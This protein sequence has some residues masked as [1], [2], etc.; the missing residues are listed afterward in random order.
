MSDSNEMPHETNDGQNKKNILIN[1]PE[2]LRSKILKNVE[3]HKL[4]KVLFASTEFYKIISS[5]YSL[6]N[7]LH[8]MIVNE[9]FIYFR[10][11]SSFIDRIKQ[12]C[13]DQKYIRKGIKESKMELETHQVDITKMLFDFDNNRIFSSSDDQTVVLIENNQVKG[14]FVGHQ[15]GIWTFGF[16]NNKLVTG[17]TDK[18]IRVW[19]IDTF[20]CQLV[21]KGHKNTIRCIKVDHEHI[22]SGGR[23][24]EIRIWNY[25]GECLHILRGH[26]QSVRCMDI[27]E[28]LLV[29]GSYDGSVVL[30]D[31]KSGQKVKQ[32][33]SHSS[34][35]YCVK[36][37]SKYVASAGID[38]VIHVSNTQ[39]IFVTVLIGHR[40]IIAWLNIIDD[41]LISAGADGKCIKYNI[42]TGDLCYRIR[43]FGHIVLMNYC[44]G[45][46]VLGTNLAVNLYCFRTGKFVRKI[47]DNQIIVYDGIFCKNQIIIGRKHDNKTVITKYTY[48]V[49]K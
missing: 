41:E 1:L 25:Q 11:P 14:T 23:D 6:W 21:L 22:I 2:E 13:M 17:S 40:S 18:T 48:K 43:E 34:R 29:S 30:W 38:S 36:M 4:R 16:F 26:T 32:L 39:G 35:V 19:D 46:L 49:Y 42:I 5:N 45:L 47:I 9:E 37:S 33:K 44:N 3:F 12:K 31:F 27:Y 24:S 20:S 28:N 8:K 10:S 7:M 15:G